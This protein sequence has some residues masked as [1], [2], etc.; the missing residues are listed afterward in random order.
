MSDRVSSAA[1]QAWMSGRPE[2]LE[3][4]V[5]KRY[6]PGKRSLGVVGAV[7]G[8]VDQPRMF[9]IGQPDARGRLRFVAYTGALPRF[10]PLFLS[11]G[12][13][14]RRGGH[15]FG[16]GISLVVTSVSMI[17]RTL[18]STQAPAVSTGQVRSP[19]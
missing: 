12:V 19:G 15:R 17:E 10:A 8:S 4:V 6:K 2:R 5:A 11:S 7:I 14:D 1:A 16:E 3:G 13:H 9:L 18:G